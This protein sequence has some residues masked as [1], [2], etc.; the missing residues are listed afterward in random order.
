MTTRVRSILHVVERLE[1]THGGSTVAAAAIADTAAV[2]HRVVVIGPEGKSD[3]VFPGAIKLVKLP[4]KRFAFGLRL[5]RWLLANGKQFDLIEMHNV[6]GPATLVGIGY[7]WIARRPFLLNPHNSLDKRDLAKRRIAKL[8]LGTLFLGPA[9]RSR[10]FVRCATKQELS[11]LVTFGW[12][13]NCDW[14][15]YPIVPERAVP[16]R[17]PRGIAIRNESPIQVLFLSRID[18]KKRIEVL[19]H[20][21]HSARDQLGA[22]VLRIAGSGEKEYE[23]ELHALAAKLDLTNHIE[24]CGFKSGAE[25]QAL[26]AEADIFVLP[27]AYENFGIVVIE[28]ICTGLKPIVSDKVAIADHLVDGVECEIVRTDDGYAALLAQVR[29]NPELFWCTESIAQGVQARIDGSDGKE[30]IWSIYERI[31]RIKD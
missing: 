23:A 9:I 25:K 2:R 11:L 17:T 8:I 28:A 29:K 19:L 30:K 26:L 21:L 4:G 14:A 12:K 13:W 18:R 27:S 22:F 7:C 5:F 16:D 31:F 15:L 3:G 20:A 10:G 6:F 24:W 1:A